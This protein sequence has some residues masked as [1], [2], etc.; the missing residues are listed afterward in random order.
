[1]PMFEFEFDI[2]LRR[3]RC[4]QLTYFIAQENVAENPVEAAVPSIPEGCA[5][6]RAKSL[7]L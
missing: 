7:S 2:S 5:L 3:I 4:K 1:M 6:E